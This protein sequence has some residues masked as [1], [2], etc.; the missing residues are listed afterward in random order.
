MMLEELMVQEF[1][2]LWVK[3][4]KKKIELKKNQQI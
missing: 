3:N 1:Q 4:N 2:L